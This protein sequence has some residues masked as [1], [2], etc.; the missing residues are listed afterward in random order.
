MQEVGKF[1]ECVEETE[2]QV[3]YTELEVSRCK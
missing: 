2:P 1:R 3:Q